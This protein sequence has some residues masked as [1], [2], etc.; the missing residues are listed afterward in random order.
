MPQPT[1]S[2]QAG[3]SRLTVLLILTFWLIVLGVL[4]LNRQA[5]YDAWRLH[6]YTAPQPVADIARQ[7]TMTSYARKIFYV[8]RPQLQSKQPFSYS[9]PNN[10]GE[11]TVILG[12][13]RGGQSG[14]FLLNVQDP[15][16][17]G[18]EQVTAAHEMLHGA[19]DR[20]SSH[21][22][23][24]VNAMLEDY[25]Q[26]DLHDERL[27][28]TIDAYKKSEPTDVVNEMHSIFGTEVSGLPAPLEDYYKRYFTD[29]SKVTAYESQYQSEFTARRTQVALDDAQL[30]NLR[31]DISSLQKQIND[32]QAELSRRQG[33]LAA[34]TNSH[35]IAGYNEQVPTYNALVNTYNGNVR[36]LRSLIDQYNTLA[37][38]RNAL[39][40]EITQLVNDLS[41]N[42]E[43]IK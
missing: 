1:N 18:V 4:S 23:A 40:S 36:Q 7:D 8:N 29:R 15:R 19:Y 39:A 22:K 3:L 14:I 21:D 9:C 34:L 2:Y 32:E 6:G 11:Q 16:L 41:T 5:L 28:K 27:L 13:Y 37:A 43:P 33:E 12:C 24:K 25:Y 31:M 26:H 20:L 10:G 17:S 42:A 38:S 35:N 30:S